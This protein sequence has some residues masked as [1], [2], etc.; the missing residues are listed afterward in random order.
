L[1]CPENEGVRRKRSATAVLPR[2]LSI[3]REQYW[4]GRLSTRK[5][6]RGFWLGSQIKENGVRAAKNWEAYKEGRRIKRKMAKD[7]RKAVEQGNTK[8]GLSGLPLRKP[9]GEIGKRPPAA[10]GC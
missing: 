7:H 2:L 8:D 1:G 3:A 4:A 9:A 10:R 6:P 5:G